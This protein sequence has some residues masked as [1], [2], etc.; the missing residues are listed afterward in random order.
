[1]HVQL[2]NAMRSYECLCKFVVSVFKRRPLGCNDPTYPSW[3]D[4]GRGVQAP[5]WEADW[6]CDG[7]DQYGLSTGT[8]V[9]DVVSPRRRRPSLSTKWVGLPR[10][11]IQ[12]TSH[13]RGGNNSAG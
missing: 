12:P 1:M 7:H 6:F 8:K 10:A 2:Q 13:A 5:H 11:V 3:P 9:V 4:P